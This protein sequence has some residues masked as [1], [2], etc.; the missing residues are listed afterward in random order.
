M[1]WP[2]KLAREEFARRGGTYSGTPRPILYT[3]ERKGQAWERAGM[4]GREEQ[5]HWSPVT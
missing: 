2:L 1:V 4:Q 3:T 5:A